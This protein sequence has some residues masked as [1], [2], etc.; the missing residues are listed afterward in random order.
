MNHNKLIEV[1]SINCQNSSVNT[2]STID[3]MPEFCGFATG[4]ADRT[5]KLWRAT[6]ETSE[7]VR[8]QILYQSM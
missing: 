8:S 5:V 3:D 1:G 6:N 7:Y 2:L 4:S